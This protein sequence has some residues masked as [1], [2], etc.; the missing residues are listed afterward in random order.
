MHAAVAHTRPFVLFDLDGTLV[1]PGS[2]LQRAHM[3]AMREAVAEL[4]DG[5]EDFRYADGDLWYRETNLSGFTDAGTIAAMLRIHGAPDSDAM[6]AEAI[7]LMLRRLGGHL[8]L[9]EPGSYVDEGL[10][11]ATELVRNV[12]AAGIAAG[13]STGNAREVASWK[14]DRLGLTAVLRTGGFGDSAR[15]RR[16][17]VAHGAAAFGAPSANGLVIG[18]TVDDIRA[19][20]ANSLPCLAVATGAYAVEELRA[21]GADLV[22]PNLT[23]EDTLP[24]ITDFIG[25][26]SLQR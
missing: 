4:C 17:L 13:L 22:V 19:A 23:H 24:M 12:H 25:L 8:D 15:D 20:H 1:R 3:G 21:A 6:V 26:G 18:D 7:D 11:G 5:V 16:L 10:P 9:M 14:V 2:G